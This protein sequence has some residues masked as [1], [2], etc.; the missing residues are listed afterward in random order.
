MRMRRAGSGFA[1]EVIESAERSRPRPAAV[2][3]PDAASAYATADAREP[4]AEPRLELFYSPAVTRPRGEKQL[5]VLAAAQ[6]SGRVAARERTVGFRQRQSR[7][8]DL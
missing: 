2:E 4:D 6:R 8:V 7:R 1:F 3:K 5:V